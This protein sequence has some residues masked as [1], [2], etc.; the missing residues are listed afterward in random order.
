[1]SA[2]GVANPGSP[3]LGDEPGI[4]ILVVEDEE[5]LAQA[6]CYRLE[7]ANHRCRPVGTL[8]QARHA[9]S[10]QDFGMV[11][12]D[13]RLPDGHGMDLLKELAER[14]VELPVLIL[15]SFGSVEDAVRAIKLGAVD[16]LIKPDDPEDALLA[17]QKAL[18]AADS[19]RRLRY[20]R[21]RDSR[22]LRNAEMVGKSELM[23][24]ARAMIRRIARLSSAEGITAPT[25]LIEGETGTGKNLAARMIHLWSSEPDRPFVQVDCAALPANLIESELFGHEKGAFTQAHVERTGLIEAAED[26]TVFLDEIGELSLDLQTKLLAVLDR[27]KVR[28]VGSSKERDVRA[29][30]IAATNRDLQAMVAQQRFRADLY[31]RLNVLRVRM[32]SLREVR[33]DIPL[34]AQRFAGEIARR[35]GFDAPRFSKEATAALQEYSWPGNVR[36]LKHFLERAMLLTQGGPLTAETLA[37]GASLGTSPPGGAQ[38]GDELNL[39]AAERRMILQALERSGGNVSEAARL[40]GLGRGALRTRM[41]RHGISVPGS[42]GSA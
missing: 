20:A 13:L 38:P 9:L 3:G 8:A 35:Y 36:E 4:D 1:M 39:S 15:T 33:A 26:G 28:R 23:E 40:L 19:A 10:E 24:E 37:L 31:F 29:R 25:V 12:L 11:L 2:S 5:S 17:V 14:T 21:T 18:R 41:V 6:L 22:V 7:R 27:R 34:L 16:Y 42:P 32:P 30:F